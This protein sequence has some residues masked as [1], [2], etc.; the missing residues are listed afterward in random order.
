[1]GKMFDIDS[2]IMRIL[3]PIADLMILNILILMC[4]IPIITMGPA[5]TGAHYVA[6]KMVRGEENYIVKGFFKS[7]KENFK[8]GVIL[9]FVMFFIAAIIVA[10]LFIIFILELNIHFVFIV[11]LLVTTIIGTLGSM[12]IFPVLAKFDNKSIIIIKNSF[13]FSIMMLPKTL[14]M[15]GAYLLPLVISYY[16]WEVFP[17]IMLLGISTPIYVS[18]MLYNKLF[19]KV[20]DMIRDNSV[21]SDEEDEDKIF[22]DKLQI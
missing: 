19:K 22:H 18:A 12:L 14:L 8:Q 6:L 2:P 7:F 9:G 21:C 10:D 5:L 17:V 3:G 15:L 1:M 20:E 16:S 13:I 4:S 11:L